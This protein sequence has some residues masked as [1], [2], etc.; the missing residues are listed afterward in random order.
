[1]A[2]LP[3]L[4]SQDS[5]KLYPDI[6]NFD[7][8]P[9][10]QWP[11]R[12]SHSF[13]LKKRAAI[14]IQKNFWWTEVL[15]YMRLWW[16]E[17]W[18][19]KDW[20]NIKVYKDSTL[21]D[22]KPYSDSVNHKLFTMSAPSGTLLE[23]WTWATSNVT[24]WVYT[25]TDSTKSRTVNAYASKWI[26]IY[27]A[28]VWTWEVIQVVSN[29]STVLTLN[30]WWLVQPTNIS[31]KIFDNY[32]EIVAFIANDWIYLIHNTTSIIKAKRFGTAI[33]CVYNLWRLFVIDIN[34]NAIVSEP[35]TN[36][37]YYTSPIWT[38]SWVQSM[39]TFQDFVLLMC[40][41]RIWMIKKDSYEVT[42]W[43]VIETFKTLTVT[44]VLWVFWKKSYTTYNQWLYVFTSAKRFIALSITPSWT[45][46][47]IVWQDDQWVYIQQ[48]LDNIQ[49]WDLV[50]I[51][52][53]SANIVFTHHSSTDNNIYLYDTYYKMR[54]RWNTNLPIKWIAVFS[55]IYFLWDKVYKIDESLSTDYWSNDYV[56]KLRSL[57]WED[58]IFSLKN[59]FMHKIYI[60]KDTSPDTKITYTSHI[61][62]VKY[63]LW[64][65]LENIKYLWD[66]LLYSW[67][68]TFGAT[69]FGSWLFGWEW[70]NLWD[71]TLWFINTIEFPIAIT[72]TLLEVVIEWD[73][74]F[75]W[76]LFQYDELEPNITPR[77][78]IAWH[79]L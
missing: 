33:D 38:Y 40:N 20:T 47:F 22:T 49:S 37:L 16:S 39:T 9:P 1:M 48:F 8:I 74:E 18:I 7:I 69:T 6:L 2:Y 50:W 17:Y 70:F 56:P 72:T 57:F 59:I 76:M 62:W 4:L 23:S 58:S 21:L 28:T 5:N 10:P 71:Y 75:W 79:S 31:Y 54:R 64:T 30:T 41:D 27:D 19:I 26:Y 61:D 36:A 43:N 66:S 12:V 13:F 67:Q 46:R 51:W 25:I 35:G 42:S 60:W 11:G 55:N 68:Q 53:N 24:T 32:W 44:N 34:N 63:S 65:T 77:N 78:S 73:I 45:D 14:N 29:T 15:D 3:M 52:I